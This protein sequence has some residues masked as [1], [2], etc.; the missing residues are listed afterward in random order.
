MIK[1]PGSSGPLKAWKRRWF[2]VY[3]DGLVEYYDSEKV[4]EDL[5]LLKTLIARLFVCFFRRAN[6]WGIST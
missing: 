6:F 2:V 5:I 3:D 4:I 1:S